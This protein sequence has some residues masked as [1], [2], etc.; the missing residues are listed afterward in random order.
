MNTKILYCL[1]ALTGLT[2]SCKKQTDG[3]EVQKKSRL[4]AVSYSSGYSYALNYAAN[5]RLASY[6]LSYKSP[7][8]TVNRF[9]PQIL[10][11]NADGT[12]Q[13][14][15]S[16]NIGQPNIRSVYSYSYLNGNIDKGSYDQVNSSDPASPQLTP[17]YTYTFNYANGKLSSQQTYNAKGE[18][19]SEYQ[20]THTVANGNPCYTANANIPGKPAYKTSTESY[21]DVLD[22]LIQYMSSDPQPS[23]YLIKS[24]VHE[25]DPK[26]NFV[27]TYKR[28]ALGRIAEVQRIYPDQTD[29][30][31]TTQYAYESYRSTEG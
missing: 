20:Y 19:T 10:S 28:D 14:I 27:Q 2:A 8:G 25:T 13:K 4:V 15:S 6:A 5:G 3:T 12:P 1:L 18:L 24:Y 11:Y 30:N 23:P 7:E 29:K 31:L 9:S 17:I 22:P 16:D 26:Q 21:A